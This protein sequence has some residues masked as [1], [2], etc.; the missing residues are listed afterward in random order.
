MPDTAV[1]RKKCNELALKLYKKTYNNLCKE[2]RKIIR[3]LV[4]EAL[5]LC[6]MQE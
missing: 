6:D 4:Y 5:G 1:V 3:D 2:R